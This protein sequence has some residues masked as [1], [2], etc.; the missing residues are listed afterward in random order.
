TALRFASKRQVIELSEKAKVVWRKV[1][2]E[3]TNPPTS[4]PIVD[5]VTARGEP[6]T[7]RIA[8]IYALM[9]LLPAVKV[10]HLH[11]GREVWRYCS[12]SARFIF[13]PADRPA[14]E[15][16][17]MDLLAGSVDGLS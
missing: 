9:D 2:C 15:A 13:G 5:A 6:Q 1:Y 7:R 16:R 17:I 4:T 3:L 11:A 12:D 14:L 10:Q 8:T